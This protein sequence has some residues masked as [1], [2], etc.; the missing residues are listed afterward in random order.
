[1]DKICMDD[2]FVC[3]KINH[4]AVVHVHDHILHDVDVHVVVRDHDHHEVDHDPNQILIVQN[5]DPNHQQQEVAV[6]VAMIEIVQNQLILDDQTPVDHV[7]VHD[8]NHQLDDVL[9]QMAVVAK[10]DLLHVRVHDQNHQSVMAVI[11]VPQEVEMIPVHDHHRLMVKIIRTIAVIQ[12]MLIRLTPWPILFN[13]LQNNMPI[14][15]HKYI[16]NIILFFDNQT[17]C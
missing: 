12:W 9:M 2:V 1:M 11:I 6:Q 7:H 5:L 17:Y 15:T 8:P 14:H 13:I 10:M 16:N 4:V 3:M